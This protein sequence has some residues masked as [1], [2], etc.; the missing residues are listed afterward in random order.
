[1]KTKGSNIPIVSCNDCKHYATTEHPS[2]GY[3]AKIKMHQEVKDKRT[4]MV[5]EAINK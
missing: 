5:K 3:C 2:V 1:M 4:C